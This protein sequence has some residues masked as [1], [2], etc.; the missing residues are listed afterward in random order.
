M[1][2]LD[3]KSDFNKYKNDNPVES[4]SIDIDEFRQRQQ[5]SS[6]D[7]Y[8]GMNEIGAA[9]EAQIARNNALFADKGKTPEYHSG[10]QTPAWPCS[11]SEGGESCI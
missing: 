9:N 8:Q 5:K 7:Y 3:T 11:P 6:A 10:S 2:D 1:S 4:H